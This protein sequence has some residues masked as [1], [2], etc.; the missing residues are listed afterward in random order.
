MAWN[1]KHFN[2]KVF[3]AFIF[4]FLDQFSILLFKDGFKLFLSEKYHL[5]F[6]P[7]DRK[8]SAPET[9]SAYVLLEIEKG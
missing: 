3:S 4:F 9:S 7:K 8:Y 2:P 6:L 1:T 5:I